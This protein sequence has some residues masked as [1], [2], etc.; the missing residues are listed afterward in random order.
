[1]TASLKTLVTN[2]AFLVGALV[3]FMPFSSAHAEEAGRPT[4]MVFG[5]PMVS[6][7]E[8][9]KI[10]ALSGAPR[11][12]ARAEGFV[13]REAPVRRTATRQPSETAIQVAEER[14]TDGRRT[15]RLPLPTVVGAFR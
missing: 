10:D 9:A 4:S 1:M 2:G 12:T 13:R 14:P 5:S 11:V 15:F 7:G 3:A 8:L 6:T